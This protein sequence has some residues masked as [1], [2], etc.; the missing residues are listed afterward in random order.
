MENLEVMKLAGVFTYPYLTYPQKY[1]FNKT[2]G[3]HGTDS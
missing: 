1:M 3:K 2:L